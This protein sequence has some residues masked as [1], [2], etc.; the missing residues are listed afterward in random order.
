M[1]SVYVMCTLLSPYQA[2]CMYD[3]DTI[4]IGLTTLVVTR[5]VGACTGHFPCPRRC[6]GTQSVRASL[7]ELSSSYA[8]Y[9]Y[10][11]YDG[12]QSMIVYIDWLPVYMIYMYSLHES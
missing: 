10:M 3:M 12:I 8:V 6:I 11:F 2:M 9:A 7:I 4:S 1:C 5:V